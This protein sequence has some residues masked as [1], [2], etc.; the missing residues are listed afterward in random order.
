MS[1][2]IEY[3]RV[4]HPKSAITTIQEQT[5]NTL[6]TSKPVRG[7]LVTAILGAISAGFATVAAAGSLPEARSETVQ[8]ADLNLSNPQGAAALYR[9]IVAAARNV[10]DRGG[11]DLASQQA[12][13][14][15]IDEA[16]ADAVTKVGHPELVGVYN[17]KSH[18]ALPTTVAAR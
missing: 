7:L 15:C 3:L 9:R 4:I 5:M 6:I 12:I 16:V 18:R 8:Y 14:A 1:E 13:R 2:A 11:F 10:C 17:A